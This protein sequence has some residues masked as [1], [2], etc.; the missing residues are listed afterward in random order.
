MLAC[1]LKITP[2]AGVCVLVAWI[3]LNSG[4]WAFSFKW[5]EYAHPSSNH[6][7]NRLHLYSKENVMEKAA[8]ITLWALI[9]AWLISFIVI[10]VYFV[11]EFIA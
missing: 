3:R 4:T 10:I 7:R 6:L 8:I 1:R 11:W 9:A 2:I 5:R